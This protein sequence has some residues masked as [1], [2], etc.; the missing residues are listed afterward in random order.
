MNQTQ[1]RVG[2]LVKKPLRFSE[3]AKRR[4]RKYGLSRNLVIEALTKPDE[5][6]KG[7]HRRKI[8]HKFKNNYVIRVIYEENDF[9][10]VITVYP[11]RRERYA[12]A[13]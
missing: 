1:T 6:I 8:A 7:H 4:I 5:V 10:M 12:E 2:R 11:A 13:I 9:I 3:H